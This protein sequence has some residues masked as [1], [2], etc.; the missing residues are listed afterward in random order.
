MPSTSNNL[1]LRLNNTIN[2]KNVINEVNNI[3]FSTYF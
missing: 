3:N 2:D 1:Q